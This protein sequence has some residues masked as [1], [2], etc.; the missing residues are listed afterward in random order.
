MGTLEVGQ[1]EFCIMILQLYG[2]QEVEYGSLNVTGPHSLLGNGM[3]RMDGCVGV[4]R[5][6]MEDVCHWGRGGGL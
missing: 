4:G 3:I 5:A 6:L 2:G 1:S